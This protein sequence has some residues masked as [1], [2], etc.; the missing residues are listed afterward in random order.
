[1]S[2]KCSNKEKLN[3]EAKPKQGNALFELQRGAAK[4]GGAPDK[5]LV[6]F[7]LSVVCSVMR[8]SVFLR[9]W[10]SVHMPVLKKNP[11][12]KVYAHKSANWT[13]ILRI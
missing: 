10:Y 2:I 5:I 11:L 7:H 4:G 9:L 8:K 12:G 3:F 1:M 6:D 13:I